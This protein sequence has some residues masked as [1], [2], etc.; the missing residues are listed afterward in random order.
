M[1]SVLFDMFIRSAF[2][3]VIIIIFFLL[4]K[5]LSNILTQENKAFNIWETNFIYLFRKHS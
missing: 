5:F 2:G 3:L 4:L 1:S